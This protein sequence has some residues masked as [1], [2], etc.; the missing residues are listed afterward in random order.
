[1]ES[2]IKLWG[3]FQYRILRNFTRLQEKE[4]RPE[5]IFK[6]TAGGYSWPGDWEGRTV[7]A[8]VLLKDITGAEPAYLENILQGLYRQLIEQGYLGE[9]FLEHGKI[10]EQ[11]LA[12]HNWL[13]RGLMEAAARDTRPFLKEMVLKIVEHLYL[14]ITGAY[15]KYPL[16]ECRSFEGEAIG[17]LQENSVN[18]WF[19]STDI[20]CAYISLDALS[21]YYQLYHD[22]RILPLLEEMAETF[23]EI[24]YLGTSM[25]THAS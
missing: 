24:D 17:E 3:E 13:L 18:D 20:G 10:N 11:Q 25:Q 14:P 15:R 16:G 2:N 1:M 8:L 22:E 12:G 21:Q 6:Q 9:R 19:L 7:L 23:M 4:Y 5:F